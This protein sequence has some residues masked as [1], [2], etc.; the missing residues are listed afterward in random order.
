MPVT[1]TAT[2]K[3]PRSPELAVGCGS[4]AIFMLPGLELAL[5][6]PGAAAVRAQG[7]CL[8]GLPPEAL[9]WFRSEHSNLPSTLGHDNCYK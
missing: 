9:L 4:E 2:N 3:A 8:L 6:Q 7:L 5:F 1:C